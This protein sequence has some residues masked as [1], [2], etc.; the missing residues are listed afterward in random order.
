M[1]RV[2]LST[3]L[4]ASAEDAYG[5]LTDTGR[6]S[7]W[8]RFAT[9]AEGTLEVGSQ[10]RVTL[11]PDGD[12]RPRVM[13]PTLVCVDPPRELVFESVFAWGLA[14]RI[15][16]AFVIE[17]EPGGTSVLWQRFEIRGPLA[18][19]LRDTLHSGVVQFEELGSDL[20]RELG[21]GRARTR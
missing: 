1:R 19:L 18:G 6:W 20:A 16:H 3:P 8:G 7:T 10:W 12:D 5:V 14:A 13:T 15:R 9:A 21:R 11:R 2:E 4:P 17:P